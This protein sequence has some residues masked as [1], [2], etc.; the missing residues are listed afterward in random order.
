[1]S[2]HPP[3]LLIAFAIA[4]AI[5]SVAMTAIGHKEKSR[6]GVRWWLLANALVCGVLKYDAAKKRN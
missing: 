3:T 1:M 5:A 6:R 2:V 4:I